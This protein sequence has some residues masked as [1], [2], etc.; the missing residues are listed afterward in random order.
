MVLIMFVV[1]TVMDLYSRKIIAG[2][3]A[4]NPNSVLV[5]Q[6]LEEAWKILWKPEAVIFH[7]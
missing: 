1:C 2:R 6:M 4:R 7:S 5:L 3:V